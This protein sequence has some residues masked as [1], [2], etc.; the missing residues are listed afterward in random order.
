MFSPD[1]PL[2]L[3]FLSGFHLFLP[4]L[5]ILM[6]ACQG[7][8]RR[9]FRLQTLFA[10]GVIAASRLLTS[11]EQNINW[12]YGFGPHPRPLRRPTLYLGAYMALLP[13]A[14]LPAH[15]V[16]NRLFRP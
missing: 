14:F 7:Y 5:V 16:L 4:P 8:D 3:R 11:R 15:L 9:A 13:V 1:D 6:L 12:V 2:Y 10:W